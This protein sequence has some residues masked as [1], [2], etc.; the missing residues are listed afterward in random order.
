M[1]AILAHH[2]D[3]DLA[4]LVLRVEAQ[5]ALIEGLGAV[6]GAGRARVVAEREVAL[7]RDVL[8]ALVIVLQLHVFRVRLDLLLE[9][10]EAL[11]FVARLDF[12]AG[13][14]EFLVG[15]TGGDDEGEEDECQ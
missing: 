9:A 2:L 13:L 7:H 11:L 15:R 12:D 6:R 14:L 4:V 10:G 1:L 5:R 8:V 3:A